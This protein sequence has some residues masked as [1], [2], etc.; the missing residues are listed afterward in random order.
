MAWG[1]PATLLVL[2]GVALVVVLMSGRGPAGDTKGPA[3]GGSASRSTT[4]RHPP[5]ASSSE[6]AAVVQAFYQRAAAHRYQDAWALASPNFRAQLGGFAAFRA[7]F[8]SLRS[9]A[10]ERLSIVSQ[11]GDRAVVAI[12][13]TAV[14]SDHV[15]R[16][17]G[18]VDAVRRPRWVVDH[19]AVAC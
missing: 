6:P 3:E 10:F 18:T 8:R 12:R 19:I 11:A 2:A 16:C 7:Q 4:A 9:I 15:D 5:V 17:S 1:I 14:H 13:T